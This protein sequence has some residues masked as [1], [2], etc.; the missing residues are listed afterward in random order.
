[1]K[2]GVFKLNWIEER[3]LEFD[4]HEVHNNSKRMEQ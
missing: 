3:H 4:M 1:M 2:I